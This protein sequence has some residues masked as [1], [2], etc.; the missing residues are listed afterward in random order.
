MEG[1]NSSVP[2][3]TLRIFNRTCETRIGTIRVWM[4]AIGEYYLS[5]QVGS[6]EPFYKKMP[7]TGS[8]L[9][10]DVNIENFYTDS[11]GNVV[12]NFK[13][14]KNLQPELVKAQRKLS[15]RYERAIRDGRSIHKSVNYQKQRLKTAKLQLKVSRQ[16]EDFQHV[17]SKELV[18]SQDR[19]FAED[20]RVKNLLQ[21]HKLAFAINDCAWGKFLN[22]VSYKSDLYGRIFRKVAAKNSTQTCSDCGYVLS[23]DEKLTLA[24][25]EWTC[26]NCGAFHNRD[27]NSAIVIK[28]RGLAMI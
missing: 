24:D 10:F 28:Q 11:E 13:F 18:E 6:M 22:K 3:K 7:E 12:P 4:N 25:R 14:K 16:R 15:R 20:L 8:T 17:R 19:L 23:G 9:G 5:L 27:H 1:S 2:K 26:P 21:N